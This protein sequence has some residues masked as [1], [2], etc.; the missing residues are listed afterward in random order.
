MDTALALLLLAVAVLICGLPFVPALHE[1]LF[2]TDAAPLVVVREQDANIR[3]FAASFFEQIQEFL[4]QHGVD[5]REPGSPF[6]APFGSSET[7]LYLGSKQRPVLNESEK[8]SRQVKSVLISA[9]DLMLE[10]GYVFENEIY[11]GRQLYAGSNNTYR[12]VYAGTDLILGPQ[13]TVARWLHSQGHVYIGENS[14]IFG[15]IS[16]ASSITLGK[17]VRFE[18]LN[19]NVIRFESDT[20]VNVS[21]IL[22]TAPKTP[23]KV[24]GSALKID[25]NTV[26]IDKN[27]E[28]PDR[29][30]HSG[31]VI[32]KKGLLLGSHCQISGNL[33]ARDQLSVGHSS[34][35]R[36]SL[37][38][39]GAIDVDASSL[40]LGPIVSETSVR[41]QS[42]CVIGAPK[43]PTSVTAPVIEIVV[44]SELS[45]TLWATQHGNVIDKPN[46]S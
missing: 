15:R 9:G 28:I 37:V 40:V 30:L 4:L 36:G 8:R 7:A 20:L 19:A 24:P 38:C 39:E 11:C 16:S 23:W 22:T 25:E 12:A 2:K 41:I 5:P 33:K 34:I 43:I 14:Q 32:S 44:G 21:K 3:H 46:E 26:L 35:V 31:N 42:E 13:S 27:V 6:T 1:W 17:G 18:R 45:G 29:A 10:G